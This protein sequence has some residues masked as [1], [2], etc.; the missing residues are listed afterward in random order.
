MNKISKLLKGSSLLLRKPYLIN[1]V[2]EDN[3]VNRNTVVQQYGFENGLPKIDITALTEKKE[4]TIEPYTFL[5]GGSLPTDY[6]LL[7]IMAEKISDCSFFEIGTWRGESA[8]NVA[9][10]AKEVFTLN[11]SVEEMRKKNWDE[12]YIKLHGFFSKEIKNIHHLEGDS[13]TYNFSALQKK[14]DVI[15]IDG[16]HH[17]ASV[18]KDTESCFALRKNEKSII[19]WHDYGASTETTRWEVLRGILDGLPKEEH[20]HLYSVSNSL[21]AVYYPYPVNSYFPEYPQTPKNN[22][23]VKINFNK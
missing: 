14:F 21:C 20:K 9:Q 16:D 17:Y 15:F 12:Q 11:L 8:A 2:L 13:L 5:E 18:K 3:E 6:M 22:F 10:I 7:K 4:Y 1:L 19:I 23:S